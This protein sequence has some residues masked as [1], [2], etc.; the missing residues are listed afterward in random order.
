MVVGRNHA[1]VVSAILAADALW[2]FGGEGDPGAWY[3]GTLVPHTLAPGTWLCPAAP[4]GHPFACLL[5]EPS[6]PVSQSTS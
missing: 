1:A 4:L 6:Q 2:D 3:L 5:A